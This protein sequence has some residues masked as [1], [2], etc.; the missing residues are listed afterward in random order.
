MDEK[1]EARPMGQVI[2]IDEAR[3]R[4]EFPPIPLER[5]SITGLKHVDGAISMARGGDKR[6][7]F[8]ITAEDRL[9]LADVFAGNR[10]EPDKRHEEALEIW[11]DLG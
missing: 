3:S 7:L 4:Q 2:Q 1:P 9:T 6:F 10:S 5:T 11:N 8:L